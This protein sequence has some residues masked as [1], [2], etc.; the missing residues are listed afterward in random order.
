M[1]IYL[2]KIDPHTNARRFYLVS[3]QDTFL[4]RWCVARAHGR[5]GR[6]CRPLP[7][8]PCADEA[9]AVALAEKMVRRKLRRGYRQSL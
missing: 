8:I 4:G 5:I 7:P 2:T 6:S 9:A 3:V 1:S